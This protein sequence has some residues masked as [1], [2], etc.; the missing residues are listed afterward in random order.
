MLRP[1]SK[2]RMLR[3]SRGLSQFSLCILTRLS[4][5]TIGTAERTGSVSKTTRQRI[6]AALG[7]P[8]EAL[9][10]GRD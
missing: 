6:A 3:E 9:F 8:S 2:M 7:V 4:P 10:D 5:G 1:P